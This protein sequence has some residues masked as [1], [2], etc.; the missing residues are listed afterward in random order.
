MDYGI[1]PLTNDH[2]FYTSYYIRSTSWT[3][4]A[5]FRYYI[6]SSNSQ[7]NMS[8]SDWYNV[9]IGDIIQMD[10]SSSVPWH[11]IFVSGVVY[12]GSGRSDLLI[13]AHTNDRLNVSFAAYFSGPR[14]YF[15]VN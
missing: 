8:V 9:W 1:I 7:L 15:H 12:N 11:N 5:D 2:W 4:C 14:T 3:A 6:T 13:C 10:N